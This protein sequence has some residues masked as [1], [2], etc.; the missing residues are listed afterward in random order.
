[1]FTGFGLANML[2]E[3]SR[4]SPVERITLPQSGHYTLA[5]HSVAPISEMNG[6]VRDS[7]WTN[8][9]WIGVSPNFIDFSQLIINPPLLH[10]DLPP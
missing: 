9:R 5:S 2:G 1:M 4:H 3:Q 6:F 7:C 10:T 8:R